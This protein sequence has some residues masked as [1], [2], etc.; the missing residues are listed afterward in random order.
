MKRKLINFAVIGCLI[1]S[2]CGAKTPSLSTSVSDTSAVSTKDPVT[3]TSVVT[4]TE[5][6]EET[7][8]SQEELKEWTQILNDPENEGFLSCSYSDPREVDVNSIFK[9]GY[10]GREESFACTGEE[11]SAY[12]ED[13]ENDCLGSDLCK[14]KLDEIEE[15]LM[16]KINL[17]R[18]DIF[19]YFDYSQGWRLLDDFDAYYHVGCAMGVYEKLYQ[20]YTVLSG[21][22]VI[23]DDEKIYVFQI[24]PTF[25]DSSY[26]DGY[27]NIKKEVALR[28]EE[29]TYY[30]ES[31]RELIDEGLIEEWCYEATLPYYGDCFFM[32][33]E[34]DRE[35]GDVTFRIVDDGKIQYTFFHDDNFV[36][37]CRFLEIKDLCWDDF[38]NDACP[39]VMMVL[40]Y[41]DQSGNLSY[42]VR[43]YEG[44]TY[45]DFID[46]KGTYEVN[47]Y[48]NVDTGIMIA[49][50]RFGDETWK[51][52][53]AEFIRERDYPA[54]GYNLIQMDMELPPQV[55]AIGDCEATGSSIFLSTKD[56]IQD[57]QLGRLYFSYI[58]GGGVLNNSEGLMGCYYDRIYDIEDTRLELMADGEWYAEYSSDGEETFTYYWNQK[59]VSET[60]YNTLLN[61]AYPTIQAVDGY[62]YK[63]ELSY[64]EMIDLLNFKVM[65]LF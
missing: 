54:S 50:L 10:P 9:N 62:V 24:E 5:P 45:G 43:L 49:S 14:V 63:H 28:I 40:S 33:Y 19:T 35:D 57:V 3:V 58:P 31:C 6:V 16:R 41:T 52:K 39:D 51:A 36:T 27:R 55:V 46:R 42:D 2:G 65:K 44:T 17:T 20:R 12:I 26:E 60:E 1:L 4:T 30:F 7:D 32:A 11:Y 53:M 59:E 56:G 8:F 47:D 34:P 64:E 37:G 22:K 29:N 23:T 25:S 61:E 18:N 21:M 48:E 38:N 15:F 13:T